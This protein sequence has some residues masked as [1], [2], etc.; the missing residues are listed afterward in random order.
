MQWSHL[1]SVCHIYLFLFHWIFPVLHNIKYR[2]NT[3]HTMTRPKNSL[4]NDSIFSRLLVCVCVWFLC[5]FIKIANSFQIASVVVAVHLSPIF[6]H[7]TISTLFNFPWI[8][9]WK[10]CEKKIFFFINKWM[11]LFYGWQLAHFFLAFDDDDDD[12]DVSK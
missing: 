1:D 6:I 12:D 11:T 7:S 2:W 9:V 8:Y 10:K 3:R 4:I 5:I